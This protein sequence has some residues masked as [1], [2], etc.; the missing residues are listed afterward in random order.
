MKHIAY[1]TSI[2]ALAIMAYSDF[3]QAQ[4]SRNPSGSVNNST[5]NPDSSNTISGNAVGDAY[6]ESENKYWRSTYPTRSY[7]SSSKDYTIYEPAYRYGVD[8][9]NRTP[10]TRYQ[11]LDQIELRN[12]WS[13]FRGESSLSWDDAEAA[14]RDAYEHMMQRGRE[15][16]E[17]N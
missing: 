5:A 15:E 8:L 11:D 13:R 7:Y 10:H 9:Y 4:S 6:W 17:N 1:I 3:T 12:R 16:Q 2:A 14:T